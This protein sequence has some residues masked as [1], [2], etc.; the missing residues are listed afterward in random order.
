LTVQLR[1]DRDLV[2]AHGS[3]GSGLVHE[4]ICLCS[5]LGD[6]PDRPFEEVPL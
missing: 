3:G 2:R 6:L 1:L 5:L 4:P